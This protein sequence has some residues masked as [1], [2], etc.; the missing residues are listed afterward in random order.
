[1]TYDRLVADLAVRTSSKIVLFVIDGLGGAPMTTSEQTE[2]EVAETPHLNA[3]AERSI[4][5]M[6]DPLAPGLTPGSGPA[7]LALFGYD[8]FK[9]KIGR[10]V[11]AALGIGFEL[12]PS[13]VA[14]RIN[15]ATLDE[16]GVITDRRAGRISTS[17]NEIL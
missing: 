16:K 3:L 12:Q 13:D 11:L 15:F 4:C 9:Y 14:V 8:P 5:G 17:T 1:M 2:L 7:H 10:G 6:M